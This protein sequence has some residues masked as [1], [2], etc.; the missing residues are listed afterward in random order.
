MSEGGEPKQDSQNQLRSPVCL[1][2][3]NLSFDNNYIVETQVKV[4]VRLN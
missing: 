1:W 4:K 2:E 3:E